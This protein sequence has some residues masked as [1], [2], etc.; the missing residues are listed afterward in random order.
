MWIRFVLSWAPEYHALLL[1]IDP[2]LFLDELHPSFSLRFTLG[3]K[4]EVARGSEKT[5]DV[6][7]FAL[8]IFQ[9]RDGREVREGQLFQEA[10]FGGGFVD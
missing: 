6:L 7:A 4:M 2:R 9:V 5:E 3:L 8:R 10:F 1:L